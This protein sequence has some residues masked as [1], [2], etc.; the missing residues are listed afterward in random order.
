MIEE[1]AS[2][3]Y[4]EYG[5]HKDALY[6]TKIDTI[7]QIIASN[8]TPILDVEPQALKVLRTREFSPFVVYIAAPNAINIEDRDGSLQRLTRESLL[9]QN[10]Y[11][12]FF[13]FSVINNDI[14]ETVKL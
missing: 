12:H 6:G 2:N 3:Q 4:L 11:K 7:R 9:L 1:I 8:R 14:E 10:I 5:S 13:D